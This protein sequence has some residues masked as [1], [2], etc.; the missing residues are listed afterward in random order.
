M[1]GAILPNF[2]RCLGRILAKMVW[3][4]RLRQRREFTDRRQANRSTGVSPDP[5]LR[6]ARPFVILSGNA[7]TTSPGNFAVP[8]QKLSRKVHDGQSFRMKW[9]ICCVAAGLVQG[10]A[11]IPLKEFHSYQQAFNETQSVA[12]EVLADYA[13]AR[14]SVPTVPPSGARRDSDTPPA[15]TNT[16]VL[17]YPAHFAPPLSAAIA[18]KP[19]DLAVRLQ[20]L[21]TVAR[22]NDILS[23]LAEGKS[24]AQVKASAKGFATSLERLQ[25]VIGNPSL[26]KLTSSLGSYLPLVNTV[27]GIIENARTR[28][29]FIEAT[30]RGEPLVRQIL[31]IFIEDTRDFYGVRYTLIDTS[32]ARLKTAIQDNRETMQKLARAHLAPTDPEQVKELKELE[33]KVAAKLSAIGFT[34]TK[35]QLPPG[36]AGASPY[37]ELVATQLVQFDAT[38]ERQVSDHNA[39]VTKMN[40]YHGLLSKYVSLLEQTKQNLMLVRAAIDAPQDIVPQTQ[41]V[42]LLVLEIRR[43]FLQLRGNAP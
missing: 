9:L 39:L 21:D 3:P 14:D 24:V 41:E 22:Y 7:L 2:L 20:A 25:S 17:P 8:T 31:D 10:C 42:F 28:A 19:D 13:D 11:Q 36:G 4:M 23:A 26:G 37:G 34:G 29:E 40:T 27:L 12:K 35:F 6:D 38:I 32:V 30:R 33:D 43:E 1:P 15:A 16:V 5:R 18:T